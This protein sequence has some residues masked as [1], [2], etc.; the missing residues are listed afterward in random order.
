MEKNVTKKL[1]LCL[2]VV[3]CFLFVTSGT[4]RCG[5]GDVYI[6]VGKSDLA[7]IHYKEAQRLNPSNTVVIFLVGIVSC[8]FVGLP[9]NQNGCSL[10]CHVVLSFAGLFFCDPRRFRS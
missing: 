5:M 7:L 1:L 4:L 8:L 6:K 10:Q 2:F 3:C 9:L